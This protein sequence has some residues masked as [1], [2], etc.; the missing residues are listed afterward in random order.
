ML[1]KKYIWLLYFGFPVVAGMFHLSRWEWGAFGSSPLSLVQ[2]LFK[3]LFLGLFLYGVLILPLQHWVLNRSEKLS[4][5]L[6]SFSAVYLSLP[7]IA[8]CYWWGEVRTVLQAQEVALSVIPPVV[9]SLM[10]YLQTQSEIS[11]IVSLTTLLSY[12][13]FWISEILG[14]FKTVF[15]LLMESSQFEW[16]RIVYPG[17]I[18][19]LY[20]RVH[21]DP[22]HSTLE[23]LWSRINPI[24]HPR[25]SSRL[26][27][28]LKS[29]DPRESS[30]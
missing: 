12:H 13:L 25:K 16:S 17:V 5:S 1:A 30:L 10:I 20:Y 21:W 22:H 14:P 19:A 3:T 7:L 15:Y 29:T 2:T 28:V 11:W 23:V 6:L 24:H 26:S 8:F 18:I 27:Q 4:F 9:L